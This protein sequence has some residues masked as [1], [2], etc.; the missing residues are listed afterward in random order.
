LQYFHLLVYLRGGFLIFTAY[1]IA[2]SGQEEVDP[3][4]NPVL[5]LARR[6]LPLTSTYESDRFW[7]RV[8]EPGSPGRGRWHATPLVLVLLTVESMDVVFAI[9]SIPAIFGITRDPFIVY[10]SNFFAIL[11][12][13]S[14]YF[15]LAG[16]LGRFR[17]LHYGLAGVL[18][19][20]GVKMVLE[21]PIPAW[22]WEGLAAYLRIEETSMIFVSLG[23]IAGILAVAIAASILASPEK[24]N[25]TA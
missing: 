10:T 4:K 22:H 5:K 11:G 18:A 17:F 25:G 23:V 20:V 13:R 12:L 24:S 14:L 2:R 16:L 7:V 1:K 15:L 3:G 19:F 21:E 8:R 9:D 6:F